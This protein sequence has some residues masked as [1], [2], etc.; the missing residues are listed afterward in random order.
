MD[1]IIKCKAS[2]YVLFTRYHKY[3]DDGMGGTGSVHGKNE[4]FVQNFCRKTERKR[5]LERPW[6]RWETEIEM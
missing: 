3:R 4:T 6:Q 1:K 2:K 5:A